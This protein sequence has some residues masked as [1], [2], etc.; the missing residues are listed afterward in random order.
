MTAF[1]GVVPLFVEETFHWNSTGAGL[2]FLAIMI[3]SFAAPLVGWASDRYGPRWLSVVGFIL[4]I[5]FWVLLRLVTH[6][7]LGQK[8][9]FCALL[10]LIGV[11]LTLVM[12]PLMAEVTYVVEAKEK[13][14]P[15]IFGPNGAY[16]QAYVRNLFPCSSSELPIF[17]GP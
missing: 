14:T 1:D 2:T 9:L 16:A 11:A 15:G 17:I 4:A 6:D 13:E 8:V 3:P 12:A 5:P 10:S 7:S